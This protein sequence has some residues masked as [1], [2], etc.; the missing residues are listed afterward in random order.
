MYD[1]YFKRRH[2]H[3]EE[4]QHKHYKR[5]RVAQEVIDYNM[6]ELRRILN[7]N[8]SSTFLPRFPRQIQEE[9]WFEPEPLC[10]EWA[11]VG[12]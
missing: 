12:A 8:P 9:F 6:D 2:T 3:F 10:F 11:G 4:V 7:V 1:L 5:I